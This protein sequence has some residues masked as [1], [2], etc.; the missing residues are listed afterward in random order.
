MSGPADRLQRAFELFDRINASDPR[1]E[2]DASGNPAPR[3]L[4]YAQRMSD[5][6]ARFD[7]QA[8]EVL[9]LA[10]RSQHI[11]RWQIPRADYPDGRSGYKA[12]RTRLMR[13]H[14]A[15]ASECLAEVGY[16]EETIRT[17]SQLLRKQGLK[18]DPEV[19][20][21]EDVVCL[22]F[23]EHYFDDFARDHDEE[24]L[25]EILRKTWRKMSDE[26]HSAAAELDLSEN[27]RRLL[28]RALEG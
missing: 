24:K 9:R 5:R 20:T 19:Q 6:L 17:V 28:S 12:W 18:R 3:E 16:D 4:V 2:P 25:I 13:H 15:L 7:P 1:T 26:G 14:A 21:L 10:A 11:A 23:L 8:S 27:T 22:V